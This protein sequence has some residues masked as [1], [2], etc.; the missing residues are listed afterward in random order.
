VDR[1]WVLV[2]VFTSLIG[3][4]QY[5][6]LATEFAP[7]INTAQIGEAFGNLRQKNQFASLMSMGLLAVLCGADASWPR[8][9]ILGV[10]L[11][12]VGSA[13]SASRTGLLQLFFAALCV[14]IWAS[15]AKAVRLRL[16]ALALLA[17]AAA[18][19]L[20]P[21]ALHAATG[22][23]VNGIA[24]RLTMELGCSSRTVL[25][26][27]VLSLIAQKPWFGWGVGEL[28]YAHFT[29]LYA[30]E[31]FCDILDNAHNL[32]LHLAV[33]LG[34]PF[35]V[36]VCGGF[37]WWVWR[38]RPWAEANAT[39]QL[40]WGVMALILLHSMVEYPLWYGPF[41]MSFVLCLWMLRST[42]RAEEY[43]QNRLLAGEKHAGV[44]PKLI[45]IGLLCAT[46]YVAWDYHRISQIYLP[47]EE[48]S[49]AYRD[50]TLEKVRPSW[51][52][53]PQVRFAEVVL[54]PV[55]KSNAAYMRELTEQTLHYSPE[56]RVIEKRIEA[57]SLLR[58]DDEALFYALRYKVAFAQDYAKWVEGNAA[59]AAKLPRPA[60]PAPN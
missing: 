45:A 57:A 1:G 38:Q 16:V 12:A 23:T 18:A 51:L 4:L 58:L 54:T 6:G 9:R 11:L 39:R 31:R 15:P 53:A 37:A 33:E 17:Y 10:G 21:L 27:N 25:W 40:A 5:F 28:D 26:A 29:N 50:D 46:A 35:A 13:A 24:G 44:A 2:A 47:P 20:L 43:V 56:P 22:V 55:D 52:F 36:L 3:L 30:G 34:L 19:W 8:A 42:P 32:P 59:L 41:F 14:G 60:T 7:W 48:R 49:A